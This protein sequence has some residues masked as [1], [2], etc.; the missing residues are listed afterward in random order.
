MKRLEKR[1]G[2]K[3]KKK[4]IKVVIKNKGFDQI[5]YRL[6]DNPKDYGQKG[7]KSERPNEGYLSKSKDK[8]GSS[9][10]YLSN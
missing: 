7:Q 5:G 2:T 6:K 3:M 4:W 10:V 1:G 9:K 8:G